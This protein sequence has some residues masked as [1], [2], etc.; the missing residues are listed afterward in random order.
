M[1]FGRLWKKWRRGPPPPFELQD[2]KLILDWCLVAGQQHPTDAGSSVLAIDVGAVTCSENPVFRRWYE[3]RIT[4]TLGDICEMPQAEMVA[5]PPLPWT[6][7]GQGIGPNHEPSISLPV[8]QDPGT[9]SPLVVGMTRS[10]GAPAIAASAQSSTHGCSPDRQSSQIQSRTRPVW[11]RPGE[12][13]RSRTHYADNGIVKGPYDF[14]SG[15]SAYLSDSE[16]SDS[17]MAIPGNTEFNQMQWAK[18]KARAAARASEYGNT[19]T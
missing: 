7:A 2:A 6:W 18:K 13:W 4:R 8:N 19:S 14:D 15:D 16:S 10:A 3:K 5:Q 12:K 17:D 11:R 1:N 9:P